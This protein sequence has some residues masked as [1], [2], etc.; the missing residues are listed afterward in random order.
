MKRTTKKTQPKRRPSSW[1]VANLEAAGDAIYANCSVYACLAAAKQDAEEE[2]D[3]VTA[4]R[5]AK[6]IEAMAD[7]NSMICDIRNG[8]EV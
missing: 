4:A 3:K 7:L 5:I 8:K 6:A 1:V 2:G